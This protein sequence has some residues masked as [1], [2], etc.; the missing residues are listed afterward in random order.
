MNPMTI[1]DSLRAFADLRVPAVPFGAVRVSVFRRLAIGL[2]VVS[3]A[4][5]SHAKADVS[6]IRLYVSPHGRDSWTGAIPAPNA[7]GT[8]RKGPDGPL[9]TL[10]A[11]RDQVRF[12]KRAA[13]ASRRFTVVIEDGTYRLNRPLVFRPDDS[14]TLDS[15]VIYRA[16]TGAH[17]V[18]SGGRRITGWRRAGNLW[19]ADLRDVREGKWYFRQLF[20]NGRRR[21]R[22]RTPN[23]GFLMVNGAVNNTTSDGSPS[24]FRY[25]GD[26]I[27]AEWAARGDVEVVLLQAWAEI[28]SP[29]TAV[30][31]AARTIRLAGMCSPSNREDN[32][33]YWVE[34][35]PECLDSP[36]EWYLDRRT[37]V[38]TYYPMPGESPDKVEVAAPVVT[39]L[40]GFEGD[41]G[42]GKTVDHIHLR[43]LTFAHADWSMGAAG[44]TDTQAAHDIPAAIEAT[45]A[46]DCAI[47][48][49][50]IHSVG[51]YALEFGRGCRGCR[52]ERCEMSDLGA[53]GVKIG[54]PVQ[55][56][57]PADQS[58]GNAVVNSRIHDI[59]IVYPAA[60]GV[61][62][63]Q[64]RDNLISHNDI[65]DTCYSTIS[66]GWT[67]GYGPTL[68][69]G[70]IIEYNH[71]YNI[72]RNWLS[73][74]GAV[75][76][77]GVQPGTVIRNN[78]IHDVESSGY[79]GWGLYTDEGSSGI[80]LENNI[81][82]R[83]K[84]GGFHQHYGRENIVRNN[85]FAL[86]REAQIIRTREEEHQSFSFDHN[87]VYFDHG[88]LLGSNWTNDRFAMDYNL[89]WDARGVPITFAGSSLQEWMKRGHDLHSRIADPLF[90]DPSAGDFRLRPSSPAPALGFK[91]IDMSSFGPQ[92][93]PAP[94]RRVQPGARARWR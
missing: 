58:S 49:C 86:A 37:G 78:L 43:G 68:A 22:A 16:A 35:A 48:N 32:A 81:V 3:F 50:R 57:S 28:R 47:E 11:A 53:G 71:L 80:L 74:M 21:P 54:E 36:G 67:W 44:Y 38:L 45:G 10:E 69:R 76:T 52:V 20:V 40:V 51:G 92:S 27:R 1:S 87:I 19:K 31:T 62:I 55:R 24:W 23:T 88:S 73:D 66:V 5:A 33:R 90:M 39:Q 64:S 8:D 14:G 82:Y 25:R 18:I 94:R 6:E 13:G 9:A 29:I 72:G 56:S 79:G 46:V 12:L 60:V 85:I 7:K 63:G 26:D 17:P 2:C 75:Y 83:T 30:D 93:Q 41:P 15:P 59:G 70:N 89:Y 77:L 84:S 61:W 65:F 42:S 4:P 34:N 91:P